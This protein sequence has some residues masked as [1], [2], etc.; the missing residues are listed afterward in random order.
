MYSPQLEQ[1]IQLFV[2][3]G[4]IDEEQKAVLNKRAQQE[5]V[6]IKELKS[7]VDSLL[8]K[9]KRELEAE[10][11]S[12]QRSYE[13]EKKN[14]I[15]NVCPECGAQVPPM[16]IVCPE[17]GW[18]VIKKK[19]VSSVQALSDKISKISL[20][21]DWGKDQK[22]MDSISLFPVPNTKED[23]IEFLALSVPNAKQKGGIFGTVVKRLCILVPLLIIA[24]V[25]AYNLSIDYHEG[26]GTVAFGITFF[27]GIIISMI[28]FLMDRETL[29]WN[30]IA[31]VWRAKF[32][33]VLLKGR[34]ITGDPDF[35]R[36][37]D[38]Y[39]KFFKK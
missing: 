16:S 8:T 38:Y 35:Q 14:A 12:N 9:R 4:N 27:G 6:D 2:E 17:C 10:I 30:K 19:A 36:Q 1:L 25:V 5:G 3:D 24:I 23:I 7:Y 20:S 39:E 31:R 15:G 28:T 11:R 13:R 26:P 21:D 37:L 34:T 32:E 22:I 29:R 18:K 33:Q